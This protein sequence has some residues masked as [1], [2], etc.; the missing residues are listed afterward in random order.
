MFDFSRILDLGFKAERNPLLDVA[1]ASYKEN[2]H[3]IMELGREVA[4]QY[5]LP[6]DVVYHR[7]G[8]WFSLTKSADLDFTNIKDFINVTS[9]RSKWLFSSLELVWRL[10][11]NTNII[12]WRMVEKTQCP[13]A[14]LS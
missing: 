8:F 6:I 4:A 3:D 12:R 5:D 10:M 11:F 2:V 1:R 7:D 13:N 9:Q 14:E